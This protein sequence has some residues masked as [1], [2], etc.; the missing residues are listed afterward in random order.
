MEEMPNRAPQNAYNLHPKARK[1]TNAK[2]AQ[3]KKTKSI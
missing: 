3:Q 2:T 1:D